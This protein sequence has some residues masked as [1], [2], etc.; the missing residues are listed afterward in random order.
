[1]KTNI[2]A[3]AGENFLIIV[4]KVAMTGIFTSRPFSLHAKN[5]PCCAQ[6]VKCRRQFGILHSASS[7][8]Q[9]SWNT[10]FGNDSF[11]FSKIAGKFH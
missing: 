6:A 10:V 5:R 8:Y 7:L 9:F 11:S 3:V 2:L 1:M 4:L